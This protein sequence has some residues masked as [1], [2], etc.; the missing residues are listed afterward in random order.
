M[1]RA[2]TIEAT[3]TVD[4]R[5]QLHLDGPLPMAGPGRVRVLVIFEDEDEFPENEWLKAASSSPAFDFLNDPEEDIYTQNDGK[6][7]TISQ[8]S[9]TE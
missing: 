5:R 4:D 1:D 9:N 7:F 8:C 2:R 6:P 3:G